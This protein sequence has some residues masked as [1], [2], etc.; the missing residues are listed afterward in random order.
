[1]IFK[2]IGL[3][4]LRMLISPEVSD[5]AVIESHYMILG[6]AFCLLSYF[7]SLPVNVEDISGN[8]KKWDN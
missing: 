2:L 4:E 1:M 6:Y 7:F 5:N 8:G 3:W